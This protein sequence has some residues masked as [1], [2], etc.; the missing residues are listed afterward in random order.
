MFLSHMEAVILM[1]LAIYGGWVILNDL[2]EMAVRMHDKAVPTLSLL[3]IIRDIEL[4]TEMLVR[5]LVREI[6]R[7][8]AEC[9]LVIA[10]C[11]SDGFTGRLLGRLAEEL[12]LVKVVDVPCTLR[13]VEGALPM[14]TGK[15]VLV[16]DLGGR[17]PYGE[18]VTIVNRLLR[19]CEPW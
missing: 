14:C 19:V 1:S 9:D 5:E 15:A 6:S 18:C 2:W 3:L 16:L 4:E 11:S 7:Q 8:D 13:P 10:N 12:E 17:L